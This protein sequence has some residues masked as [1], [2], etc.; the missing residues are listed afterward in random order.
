ME[1]SRHIAFRY[2]LSKKSKTVVNII[3]RV[4]LLGMMVGTI[5]LVIVLSVFNGFDELI[6]SF[7]SVFDS[8]LKISA[9]EGKYFDPRS[10]R[11]DSI[12]K[13]PDV[14]DYS[15]EL[16]EI[17]LLQYEDRQFIARIKGVDDRYI[18][19][20][21]VDSVIYDGHMLLHDDNLYYAVLGR[22]VAY[23]LGATANLIKPVGISVPKKRSHHYA[24]SNPFRQKYLY[25]SGIYVV[26]QQ[27]VDDQYAL[28]S[29]DVARELLGLEHEVSALSLRLKKGSRV[30]QVQ[31][32][33][34]Q[35]LGSDYVV[36]NRY[37]QH[38]SYYR[39]AEVERFFIF[40]IF[41]FILIIAS[42]NL[43]GSIAMQIIDKKR[44]IQILLSFGVTKQQINR[45]FFLEGCFVSLF[46]AL[47]GIIL[48][49]LVCMGQQKF[50]WLQMPG[51][52]AVEAYPVDIRAGSLVL[53]IFTVL[54]VGTVLSWLPV[55]FMPRKF[56]D[57]S[58]N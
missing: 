40:L 5:A 17:A 28:V 23:N 30:S 52:F 24:L 3:S 43:I 53:I 4:A 57:I 18:R 19:V 44:D 33:L 11:F 35:I 37:E 58:Q 10:E 21:P 12:K 25:V 1:I 31:K 42:F 8:E 15:E 51:G 27:E 54:A 36:Q 47:A 20:C 38:E 50:G 39:V 34:S 32:E 55:R 9:A 14:V 48:G 7:F 2:L 45:I 49:I 41:V 13:H 26:G 46:G 16:E 29:L 6:K 56:F 22:G